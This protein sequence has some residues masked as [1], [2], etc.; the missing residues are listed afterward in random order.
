MIYLHSTAPTKPTLPRWHKQFGTIVNPRI[1]VA[2]EH[3]L[4]QVWA[5]DNDAFSAWNAERFKRG[6]DYYANLTGCLFVVVPDVVCD[7]KATMERWHEWHSYVAGYG[8][9]LAFVAQNGQRLEDVP[10]DDIGTLFIGGDNEYKLGADAVRLVIEAHKRGKWVHMGRVNSQKRIRYARAIGC[11][12][13]DGTR[14][15][16]FE[17]AFAHEIVSVFDEQYQLTMRE[18]WSA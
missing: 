2:R 3:M 14:T 17:S 10:F 11:D 5:M 13:V 6:L 16:R 15:V 12:S 18:L 8:Y 7:A 9:P 1:P 4:G